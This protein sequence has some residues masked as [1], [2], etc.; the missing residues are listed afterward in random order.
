MTEMIIVSYET[1]V[2]CRDPRNHDFK[3]H[4]CEYR[5]LFTRTGMLDRSARVW[6]AKSIM[7]WRASKRNVS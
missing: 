1:Q 3:T 5:G 4:A 7:E 6:N 2:L